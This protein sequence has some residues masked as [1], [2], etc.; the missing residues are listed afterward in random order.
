[1]NCLIVFFYFHA[2]FTKNWEKLLTFTK[3]TWDQSIPNSHKV[4]CF[5]LTFL[6]FQSNKTKC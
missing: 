2:F 1:M 3:C 6:F 5:T 4:Y